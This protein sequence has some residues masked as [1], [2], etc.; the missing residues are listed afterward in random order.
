M[1]G[2]GRVPNERVSAHRHFGGGN[3]AREREVWRELF[4]P[5]SDQSVR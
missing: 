2:C 4:G 3:L 1:T 5:N